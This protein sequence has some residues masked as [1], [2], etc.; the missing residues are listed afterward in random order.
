MASENLGGK[1]PSQAFLTQCCRGLLHAQWDILL[2]EEFIDVYQHGIPVPFC[3][4]IFRRF[5][6]Q[7]FTHSTDY[8]EK[9]VASTSLS[10]SVLMATRVNLTTIQDLG[11]C[12]CPRCLVL[13]SNVHNNIGKKKDMKECETRARIEDDNRR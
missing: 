5:Y 10:I 1:R 11:C 3:D 12:P 2:D 13:L 4:V 8:K 6:P 9:Y 7:Y